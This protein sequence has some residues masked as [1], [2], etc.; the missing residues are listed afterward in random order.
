MARLPPIIDP[1]G[2]PPRGF[3][4]SIFKLLYWAVD[5]W[6]GYLAVI[7]PD[8]SNPTLVMFDRY[9]HDVLVDPERYR[10]PTSTLGFAQFVG[11][12]VRRLIFTFCWMFLLRRCNRESPK[13]L[14]QNRGAKGW[15]TCRCFSQYPMLASLTPPVLSMRSLSR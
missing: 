7:R 6:Y 8:P 11:R 5:Y 2:K 13:S 10:L 15:L 4:F 9:Y 12:L 14:A 1:H 3:L